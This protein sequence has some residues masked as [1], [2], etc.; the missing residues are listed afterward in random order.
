M[1]K[2]PIYNDLLIYFHCFQLRMPFKMTGIPNIS[3]DIVFGIISQKTP[4]DYGL[5]KIGGQVLLRCYVVS[6]MHEHCFLF[7]SLVL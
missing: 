6:E 7:L 5:N 3:V 2:K 4:N 1:R